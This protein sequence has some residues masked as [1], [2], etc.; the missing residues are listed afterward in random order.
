MADQAR[1]EIQMDDMQDECWRTGTSDDRGQLEDRVV[2][3]ARAAGFQGKVFVLAAP[4]YV[5]LTF[6]LVGE[7]VFF[8]WRKVRVS[9]ST[10]RLR[11]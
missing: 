8:Q 11:P 9:R 1:Q 6:T 5:A 2:D 4:G 10:P 3:E 7:E